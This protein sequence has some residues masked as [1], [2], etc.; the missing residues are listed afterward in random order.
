[1]G[2]DVRKAGKPADAEPE[3][4]TFR[5]YRADGDNLRTLAALETEEYGDTIAEVFN[6]VCAPV[7]QK[8]LTEV[9]ESRLDRMKKPRKPGQ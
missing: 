7:L 9:M 2:K 1:M 6:R 4:T 8:V 3:Y 5:F